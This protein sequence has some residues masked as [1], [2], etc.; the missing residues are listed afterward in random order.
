MKI[1]R[2]A[3][4]EWP[5]GTYSDVLYVPGR[6]TEDRPPVL[7]EIQDTVDQAFMLRLIQ[8]CTLVVERY[9]VLPVVLVL[10]TVGFSQQTLRGK[11]IPHSKVH[12]LLEAKCEFWAQRMSFIS[13]ESI[14][15]HLD[16]GMN[17]L[18]ALAYFVTRQTPDINSLEFADDPTV[19]SLYSICKTSTRRKDDS[20]MIQIFNQGS[21]K[22]EVELNSNI[23]NVA[24]KKSE[25][26]V[27]DQV[28]RWFVLFITLLK[29][30]VVAIYALFA[31]YYIYLCLPMFLYLLGELKNR[32]VALFEDLFF[33]FWT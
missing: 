31:L 4:T 7:V 25:S 30:A 27:K 10:V 18:V 9:K 29:I 24:A 33:F 20:Q 32:Y 23:L 22:R 3:W 8:H 11:L 14:E 1:F 19:K 26:S 6:V 5:D 16:K 17:K 21:T 15:N 28:I 13:S 2:S 12:Y